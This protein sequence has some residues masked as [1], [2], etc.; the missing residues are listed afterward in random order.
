MQD[1]IKLENDLFKKSLKF[2]ICFT[3]KSV[4]TGEKCVFVETLWF[5]LESF[6]IIV[7]AFYIQ[8]FSCQ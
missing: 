2:F 3:V 1:I 7:N 6:N 5:I 4:G 8:I